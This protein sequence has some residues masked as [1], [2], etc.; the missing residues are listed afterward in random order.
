M[1]DMSL[2]A[3]TAFGASGCRREKASSL[4]VSVA[5]RDAAPWAAVM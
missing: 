3:F 2:L 5:A 4:W 1:P